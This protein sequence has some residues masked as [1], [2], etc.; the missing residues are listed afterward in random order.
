MSV[1]ING[2]PVEVTSE[3][4]I[5]RAITTELLVRILTRTA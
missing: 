3:R 4:E 5:Q 2:R 1:V